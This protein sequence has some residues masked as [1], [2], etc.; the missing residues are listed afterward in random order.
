MDRQSRRRIAVVTGTRA[1]YG[2]IRPVLREIDAH[3]DLELSLI[4]MA[5]H[6]SPEFHCT[7]QEIEADGFRIS[8]KVE[9][10]LSSDS[11]GGMVRALGLAIIQ[12]AQVMEML[13]PDI[14][15]ATG[16]RGE[17]L[18]AAIVGAHMNI[19]VAH[20][21]G[22]EISGTVDES[23]RHA[24]TKFAHIHLPAT[25]QSAERIRQLGEDADRIYV[26]GAIGL[27]QIREKQYLSPSEVGQQLDLDLSAPIVLV[28]QHPVTT[29]VSRAGAQM[30]KTME[31]IKTVGLQTVLIYPNSDAGGRAMCRV[32][33]EYEDLPNVRRF[34][35]APRELYLGLMNIASVMV[36]N[37][38]SGI[39]EAPSFHL[40]FVNVGS[41]QSGRQRGE[42]VVDVSYDFDEIAGAIRVAVSDLAFRERVE[43]ALNPYDYGPS[44]GK[45]A[46]ILAAVEIDA[47]LIQKRMAS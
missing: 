10:L 16:D 28:S 18:A 41:R 29:E 26:V 31:A 14:I 17:M 24:I 9:T 19:P 42:N 27:E 32:I 39:I 1:E 15:V 30:R 8:A 22:G 23:I 11:G 38:S 44:K 36:G 2:I 21:H 35:N 37:S 12:L 4:A 6:L 5:Q 43:R 47:K 46:D 13:R 25:Q 33:D 3:P 40:P 20:Q 34:V 7:V 45:V